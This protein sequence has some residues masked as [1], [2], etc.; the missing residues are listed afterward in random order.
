M[1]AVNIIEQIR[2]NR[3]PEWEEIARA[4]LRELP[5]R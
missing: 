5:G 3:N 4:L 1:N 2:R